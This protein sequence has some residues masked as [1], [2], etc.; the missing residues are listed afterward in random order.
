ML[1]RL[2]GGAV[3]AQADR[4]VRTDIDHR[5]PHDGS[6]T[7]GRLHVIGED[8]EGAAE[9][10]KSAMRGDAVETGGHTVLS[11]SPVKGAPRAARPKGA[12][13]L[14]RGASAATEIG[15]ATHQVG[16]GSCN[17]LKRHPRGLP[18]GSGGRGR[19]QLTEFSI[20]PGRKLAGH[21][22]LELPC[23]IGICGSVAL[24]VLAPA[25][26]QLSAPPDGSTPVRESVFWDEE[27]RKS[28]RLNSSHPSI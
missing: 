25:A 5:Q 1:H 11:N 13:L 8:Q 15:R 24:P 2:V 10:S 27:D 6:E 7:N 18:R 26:F 22:L 28:T 21:P 20:P 14:Q 23:E 9:H 3:L 19:R 12:A 17:G 16:D 4:V